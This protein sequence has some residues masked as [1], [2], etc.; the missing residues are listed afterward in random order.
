MQGTWNLA[1]F[2]IDGKVNDL[3]PNTPRWIIKGDKVFYG[4]E[5]LA[6]LTI[7]ATAKPKCV[8]LAFRNPKRVYEGVYSI[9]ADTLQICANRQT[10]GVKER[11][12]DFVT[13]G[14][15]DL[16]L[17]IFKRDK[18][19]TDANEGLGGYIGMAIRAVPDRKVLVVAD[20]LEGAPAKKAGLRKDDVLRK[21]GDAEATDLRAFID[22]V[23]RTKPGSE[24]VIHIERSGKPQDI[25][26]KIGVMPF[27][28]LD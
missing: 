20:V 3:A 17:L 22:T 2:E 4:G 19:S 23:R 10:E 18:S 13:A 21:I 16:R 5:E 9:A 26:V 15:P 6:Q 1:S 14:K 11:P 28:Y 8:D 24:L 12:A 27:G 7:D 25:T